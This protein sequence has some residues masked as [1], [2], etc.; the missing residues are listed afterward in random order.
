MARRLLD[1]NPFNGLSTYFHY[2]ES[3]DET[4]IETVG[5][6]TAEV[7]AAT[8]LRNNEDYTRKG[9]KNDFLHYAHITDAVLMKWHSMGVDIK[10]S[11]ELIKMVNKPEWRY[12]KTTNLNHA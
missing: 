7:E 5:D 11:K 6:S 1:Y 9:M 10:D 3:T 4:H 8:Q 2:D 12:L